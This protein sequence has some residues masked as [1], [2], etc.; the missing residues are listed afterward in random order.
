M[1]DDNSDASSAESAAPAPTPPGALT[2]DD[3]RVHV[4]TGSLNKPH[5]LEALL[6]AGNWLDVA[7]YL[8]RALTFHREEAQAAVAYPDGDDAPSPDDMLRAHPE[9]FVLPRGQH[10]LELLGDGKLE[11][12]QQY[13]NESIFEP[14]RVAPRT[15]HLDTLLARLRDM[16][17]NDGAAAQLELE[18][19]G[20]RDRTSRHIQDYLRVY[21]PT[22]DRGPEAVASMVISKEPLYTTSAF[23]ELIRDHNFRC[24]VCHQPLTFLS[25]PDNRMVEHLHD[26]CP[27]ITPAIRR[28][29]PRRNRPPRPQQPPPAA[30][31]AA[32]SAAATDDDDDDP[33]QEEE[34]TKG[35]LAATGRPGVGGGRGGSEAG[36]GGRDATGRAA[37][38]DG[39]A[40]PGGGNM[41]A[42]A[43]VEGGEGR[44]REV[45]GVG[46]GMTRS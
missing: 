35:R 40:V 26:H 25:A 33:Q 28:R 24:L 7:K 44:G 8:G 36:G 19:P 29:L 32:A 13:F 5:V 46:D 18:L 43:V 41:M 9:L 16:I 37:V 15:H 4:L 1:A 6:A 38:E 45:A 10:A 12:A 23:G 3:V 17:F 39:W 20:E 42:A 31:A 30:A 34:K 11:E 21:F 2:E 22:L 14:T 27:A